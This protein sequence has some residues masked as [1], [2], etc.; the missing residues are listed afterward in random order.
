VAVRVGA[1]NEVAIWHD[2][3]VARRKDEE[4]AALALVRTEAAEV[5]DVLEPMIVDDPQYVGRRFEYPWLVGHLEPRNHI[6]VRGIRREPQRLRVHQVLEQHDR[7]IGGAEF[8]GAL[9]QRMHRSD[10]DTAQK[11]LYAVLKIE[12]V[13]DLPHGFFVG[14]AVIR[15][16]DA[17]AS[18]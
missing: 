17:N 3:V 5:A 12:V 2:T 10:L 18:L 16:E 15:C 7:G 9:T 4:L 1:Q 6:D 8:E 14:H 13:I 11:S